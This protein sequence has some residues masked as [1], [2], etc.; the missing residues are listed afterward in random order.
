MPKSGRFDAACR[1]RRIGKDGKF[2][3]LNLE[4]IFTVPCDHHKRFLKTKTKQEVFR[5]GPTGWVDALYSSND[6]I[7]FVPIQGCLRV[8]EANGL[9]NKH[10]YGALVLLVFVWESTSRPTK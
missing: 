3:T 6:I 10:P 7:F 9:K 4:T 1:T 8:F 5:E 2:L